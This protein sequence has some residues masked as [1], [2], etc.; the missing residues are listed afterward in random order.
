MAVATLTDTTGI[1]IYAIGGSNVS[2]VPTNIVRRYNPA[3]DTI[4]NITTDPW[5]A[6]PA[7][8]P[9]GYA[10][11]DNKLYIFGGFDPRGNGTVYGDTWVFNP[12]AAAGSRWSQI[13]TANLSTARA[14]IAGAA[15]DG[16]IYAIGGDTWQTNSNIELRKLVPSSV[17]ERMDPGIDLPAWQPVASLP[18]PKGDAG[19][20]AYD[21]GTGYGISGKLV[22]AGGHS[23]PPDSSN[24][25]VPNAL[26]YIL[27]PPSLSD[28]DG[29]WTSFIGLTNSTR[30]FGVAALDGFL[31]AIGG[32]DYS[33]GMPESA[34]F[35]QRFDANNAIPTTTPVPTSTNT[36]TPS[37]T[38][39]STPSRTATPPCTCTPTATATHTAGASTSTSTSVGT[40]TG[41]APA[42]STGTRTPTGTATAPAGPSATPTC[43]CAATPT[44]TACTVEFADVDPGSTFYP[45][46]HCLACRGIVGGYPC[47]GPDEPCGPGAD[48]YYRPSS[49]ITRGQIAKIVS[50]SAGLHDEQDEQFYQDVPPG[51]PFYVW[52]NRL[53]WRGYMGGYACNNDPTQPCG[54]GNLPYFRPNAN[55]TRGQLSKIVANAAL[56]DDPVSGQTY[57]DVP[58][59]DSSESFYIYIE[60]LT[61]RNVMGGYACGTPNSNSGP[62]DDQQRPYFRPNNPVT[63]GQA[64]KIVANTFFP[65]CQTP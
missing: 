26:A 42:T 41:T 34:G 57:Q 20:W 64:A 11:L 9:G 54:P 62:C 16:Y 49:N 1:A 25:L 28:A 63:R 60:R 45:F 3:T 7:R 51:S 13:A 46:V 21:T 50:E 29:A 5:P 40:V 15:L 33:T 35:T 36:S 19:A 44:S 39:S 32:Y 27:D 56:I 37:K 12:M 58:P 4:S 31:Y 61:V 6:N 2:S 8:I 23:N 48:A 10:V 59:S 43:V 17:V 22:V 65:N 30:N 52:I 14:Y 53:S 38:A 47:G 24:Y 55:A 18:Q